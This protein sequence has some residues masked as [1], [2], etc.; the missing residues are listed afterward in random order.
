MIKQGVVKFH[1]TPSS[2]SGKPA[3]KYIK[4]E[5]LAKGEKIHKKYAAEQAM[6]ALVE[7]EKAKKQKENS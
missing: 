1:K 4:G 6:D 3:I 5:P 7:Y 2:E